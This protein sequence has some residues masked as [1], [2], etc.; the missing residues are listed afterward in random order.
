MLDA[1]SCHSR[2]KLRNCFRCSS[3]RALLAHRRQSRAYLRYS[4]TVD[5]AP[6]VSAGAQL[7]SQ[8]PSPTRRSRRRVIRRSCALGARI[9]NKNPCLVGNRTNGRALG[10]GTG[11]L[12]MPTAEYFRRQADIC[13]RLSLIASSEEVMTRLIA[14]AQDY[15]AR[16]DVLEARARSSAPKTISE[17]WN[18]LE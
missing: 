4:S 15:H 2:A 11:V 14:M 10:G 3:V 18:Q 16:I 13:I 12:P 7:V 1:A 9:A 17:D 5:M 6:L 8:P